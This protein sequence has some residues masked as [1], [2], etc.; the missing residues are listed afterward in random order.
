MLVIFWTRSSVNIQTWPDNNPKCVHTRYLKRATIVQKNRSLLWSPIPNS[1]LD[2]KHVEYCGMLHKQLS[3]HVHFISVKVFRP[4]VPVV[5]CQQRSLSS[6]IHSGRKKRGGKPHNVRR[7]AAVVCVLVQKSSRRRSISLRNHQRKSVIWAG[8][9]VNHI[10][11]R[12]VQRWSAC[13]VL[14]TFFDIKCF[15]CFFLNNN[16]QIY[17]TFIKALCTDCSRCY[18]GQLRHHAGSRA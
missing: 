17:D 18:N 16:W 1:V 6:K 12:N 8:Q 15:F 10:G 2:I 11:W 9:E 14:L 7:T 3:T 5:R 4:A 13:S